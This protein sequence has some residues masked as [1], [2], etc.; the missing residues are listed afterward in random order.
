FGLLP[1]R[2]R[3]PAASRLARLIEAVGSHLQTGFVGTP[4]LLQA[5]SDNG[6]H[7]L[8]CRL[9]RQDTFPSW[10]FEVR[11]GATTIW[12]RWNGWTPNDG[13]ADPSMNSFNH[14]AFG[15]I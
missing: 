14:Y 5:L 2:L 9:A 3:A 11:Q 8:A 1:A 13:F 10:G 6:L 15:C 7:E 4:V 12:E